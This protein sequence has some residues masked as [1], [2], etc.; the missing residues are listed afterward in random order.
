MKGMSVDFGIRCYGCEDRELPKDP[1]R[2]MRLCIH[3]KHIE[4]NENDKEV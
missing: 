3:Q 4:E 1:T 2:D